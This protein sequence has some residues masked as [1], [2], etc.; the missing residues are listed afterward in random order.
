M[1]GDKMKSYIRIPVLLVGSLLITLFFSQGIYSQN[2]LSA[3][4]ATINITPEEPIP[5]SGYGSRKGPFDG[6]HDSIYARALVFSDGENKAAL[7]SA[8]LI[9]FSDEFCDEVSA[10]IE[11]K[12]GI[13]KEFILITAVHSHSGPVT[14]VYYEDEY[15]SQDPG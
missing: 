4:T 7:I 9:G 12:T 5:M 1:K 2:T 14:K 11:S 8:E 6:I 10:G 13:H 3:G 15:Q